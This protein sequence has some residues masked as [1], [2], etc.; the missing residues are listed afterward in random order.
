M[1]DD[2]VV[3]K[4]SEPEK[5]GNSL[6]DKTQMILYKLWAHKSCS[7]SIKFK[8]SYRSAKG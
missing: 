2:S 6:E 1:A 5:A 4:K 7:S 3:V 8:R